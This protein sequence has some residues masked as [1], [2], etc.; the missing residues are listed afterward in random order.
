M[1]MVKNWERTEMTTIFSTWREGSEL[2][3]PLLAS[4]VLL[5]APF[6]VFYLVLGV[7]LLFAAY[8]STYLPGR[9]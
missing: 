1:R 3:T 5:F 6:Q 7:M 9:L 2:L 8:M 4:A